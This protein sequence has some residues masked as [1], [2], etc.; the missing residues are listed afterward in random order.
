V[1]VG[2]DGL[3]RVAGVGCGG[4]GE[5]LDHQRVASSKRVTVR[6]SDIGLLSAAQRLFRGRAS[7]SNAAA[8]HLGFE[9]NSSDEPLS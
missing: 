4:T 2:A 5:N 8:A 7:S 3:L 9:L 1:W 6:A